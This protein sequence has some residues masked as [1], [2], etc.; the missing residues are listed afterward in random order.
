[1]SEK[2]YAFLLRLYPSAFRKR[3]EQET[4]QLLRDRI[5]DEPGA[6][7]RLRLSLE[8]IVDV[9]QSLPQAYRNSYAEVASPVAAVERIDGVPSFHMIHDEPIRRGTF[10]V[11]GTMTIAAL[12][13]FGFVM[14]LPIPSEIVGLKGSRSPVE[15]VLDRLN[16]Q[17]PPD[18]AEHVSS[19]NSDEA[20][21]DAN[22]DAKRSV[23][24]QSP[25][26]GMA[27]G[28]AS[29]ADARMLEPVKPV[30]NAGTFNPGSW[31]SVK[32]RVSQTR[33]TQAEASRSQAQSATSSGQILVDAPADL[34][35]RWFE[36][37][38]AGADVLF[39]GGFVLVQHGPVL[40]GFAGVGSPEQSAVIRGSVTGDSVKFEVSDG[41]KSFL[42]N[43]KLE[44]EEMRGTVT[45]VIGNEIRGVEV[46]LRRV[47]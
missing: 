7:P 8:L 2:I 23:A 43:L 12:I 15:S 3:Y 42:Y 46:E 35:G 17:A 31:T 21:T 45:I 18:S 22:G 27:S 14:R 28:G 19:A 5:R 34:S 44:G 25:G 30:P 32:G 47:R 33:A 20:Q 11:A 36:S 1:M 41:R 6:F 29:K 37:Q 9:M 38:A 39:S 40:N 10:V 13:A 16:R 26:D 4:M 24:S